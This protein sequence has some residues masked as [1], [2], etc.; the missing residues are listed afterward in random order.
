MP[1]P[2]DPLP[3]PT[4]SLADRL[5]PVLPADSAPARPRRSGW[6][7]WPA[8]LLRWLAFLPLGLGLVFLLEFGLLLLNIWL[9]GDSLKE[10]LVIGVF[11]GGLGFVLPIAC[12]ITYGAVILAARRVCPGP[13]VGAV[14]F[15]VAYLFF[16]GSGLLALVETTLPVAPVLVIL[17]TKLVLGIT[18]LI[19][20][21]H[22]YQNPA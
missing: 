10:L 17:G 21:V 6:D 2:S 3:R 20:V 12:G 11:L 13:R 7:S 19:G 14:L 8:R 1:S 16:A 22:A 4:A 9:F 15:A 18:V 5:R